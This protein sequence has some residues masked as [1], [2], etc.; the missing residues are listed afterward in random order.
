M[1]IISRLCMR[2]GIAFCSV[3][4]AA[5]LFTPES[6]AQENGGLSKFDGPY[7]YRSENGWKNME[8]RDHKI[9]ITDHVEAPFWVTTDDGK[10]RFQVVQHDVKVPDW[11]YPGGNDIMVLSDPHGDFESFHAILKEQK[12]IGSDYQ[13]I[14]GKKHV[15]IIGDVFDRG[16]D[17]VPIF[18]LIYKLEE[19]A[20]KAGGKV[21]FLFGNHEEMTLRGN[22]KYSKSKYKALADELGKD[23]Q[24]L[25]GTETVLGHWLLQRNTMEKIGDNL[26]V[27][28]GLS[29]EM[30]DNKWT[31]PAVNDAVRTYIFQTKELRSQSPAATFLFGSTGPLWYRGMVSQDE[32]YQPLSE[33]DANLLLGYYDAKKLFVGHT[34]FPEVTSFYG[35][36][37]YAVNVNNKNN[38]EKGLSRGLWLKDG[39]TILIYDNP[40]QNK[41]MK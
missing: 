12:V 22:L 3:L 11:K 34:I 18:W 25:W 36:R 26:F 29:R 39:K 40:K 7:I 21:H 28:A 30:F 1:R 19:E 41:V 8:V 9:Q 33:A 35:S 4:S 14:F 2:T 20:N 17:V 32:K 16:S 27:H 23:Y 31:I 37:V 10:H 5:L 13:W 38:R 15:V 24:E 6:K